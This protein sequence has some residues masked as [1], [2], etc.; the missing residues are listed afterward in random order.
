MVVVSGV[1]YFA[2]GTVRLDQGVAAVHGATVAA[3]VLGL[4]VSGVGVGH[5]V[6]VVILRVGLKYQYYIIAICG[7]KSYTGL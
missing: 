4:V 2:H 1:L 5:G 7:L 6:S 3:L